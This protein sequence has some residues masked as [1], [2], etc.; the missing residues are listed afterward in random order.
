[1]STI[2][3]ETFRRF[4]DYERDAHAKT[5]ASLS[6]VPPEKRAA[7]EF[8]KAVDLVAHIVGAR[9]FWLQRIDGSTERPL[10]MFSKDFSLADLP[11]RVS[12]MEA[13][14]SRFLDGVTDAG[15]SRAVEWGPADGPRFT[16]TLEDVLTQLFGHSTYHRGQIALLIR[17]IGCE[18]PATEFVYFARKPAGA[19]PR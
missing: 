7:P 9:W 14:W 16:N 3:A 1:M 6:A 2:P 5:L 18:P 15:L 12:E 11:A 10:K 4:F 19:T 8:R 13:A 17:Q